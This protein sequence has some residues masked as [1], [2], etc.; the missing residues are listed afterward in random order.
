MQ[1]L[2]SPLVH[3]LTAVIE[4]LHGIGLSWGLSIIGLTVI[5]RLVLFPLTWKQFRSAQH[6]QVVQPKLRELQQKYKNDRQKLQEETMKLYQ[7]YGVNPFASCLPLILQ[8]PV[9]I[10]LYYTIRS[11]EA[12]RAATFLGIPLGERSILLL[13][14]YV[15]TQLVSTELMLVTQTDRTQKMLMRAMPFIFIAFLWNFPAGLFVYWITTNL[16]SIGQQLIIKRTMPKPEELVAKP[17]KRSRFMEALLAAQEQQGKRREGE[18][19]FARKAVAEARAGKAGP[20]KK[21]RP[22]GA[23]PAGAK[24]G[25]AKPGAAA[26]GTPKPAAAAGAGAA[27]AADGDGPARGRVAPKTGLPAKGGQAGHKK[28]KKK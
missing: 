19:T 6:M 8:L 15:V 4:W 16:W 7:E 28:R 22:A 18:E 23:K 2:L 11:E 24:P 9:F 26:A 14:V 5:V 12:I 25:A 27:A 21:P 10:A 1:S 3:L 13:V 17:R 20:A